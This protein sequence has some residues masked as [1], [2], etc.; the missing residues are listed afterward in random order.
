MDLR[1][2]AHYLRLACAIYGWPMFF[3]VT[4]A[5]RDIL[6]LYTHLQ[7]A[8]TPPPRPLGVSLGGSHKNELGPLILKIIFGRQKMTPKNEIFRILNFGDFY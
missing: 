1:I 5:R 3:F 8:H 6:Q 2:L 7:Y 4:R